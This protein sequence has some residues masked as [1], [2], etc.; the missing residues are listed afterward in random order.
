MAQRR[1][2]TLGVVQDSGMGLYWHVLA[3]V[4]SNMG[5]RMPA[6][7]QE[8]PST[9]PQPWPVTSDGVSA[10]H[11]ASTEQLTPAAE[12]ERGGEVVDV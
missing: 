4:D 8:P 11:V 3:C 12:R 10:R 6:W 9:E 2:G 7:R 5:S 1:F